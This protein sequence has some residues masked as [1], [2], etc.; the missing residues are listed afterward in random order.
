MPKKAK[1]YSKG[2]IYVLKNTEN[3]LLYVGSTTTY[4]SCRMNVHKADAT[5]S[6]SKLYAN[7]REI[8]IDKFYIELLEDFPCDSYEELTAREHYYITTY[9]TCENGYN[10]HI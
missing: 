3:S 1:D 6:N 7:M 2:K 5:K 10:T 9:N 8:G 4:L